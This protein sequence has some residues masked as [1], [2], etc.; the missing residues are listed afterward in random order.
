MLMWPT[1]LTENCKWRT[2]QDHRQSCI[3]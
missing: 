3:L 1:I 2:S